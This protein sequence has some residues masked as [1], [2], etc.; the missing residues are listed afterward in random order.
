MAIVFVVDELA[1]A[2][3]IDAETQMDMCRVVCDRE[4]RGPAAA[5]PGFGDRLD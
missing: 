5:E 4:T 3:P 2:D 1:N